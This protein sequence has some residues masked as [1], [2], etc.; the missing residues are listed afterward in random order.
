[1][2]VSPA[3]ATKADCLA[4]GVYA[5]GTLTPAARAVDAASRGA[6]RAAL[7]SGDASGKRGA[8]LLLRSLAQVSAPRVLL[9]GLGAAAEF[10]DK[11]F[12]EAVRAAV[13]NAGNSVRDLAL[14]ALDWKVKGH[15]SAWQARMVAMV[16]RD[17]VFRSDE[18]KSRKDDDA[19]HDHRQG[20]PQRTDML[21]PYRTSTLSNV[22][23]ATRV[24]A[25]YC[26]ETGVTAINKG[27]RLTRA[28]CRNDDSDMRSMPGAIFGRRGEAWPRADRP[29]QQLRSFLAAGGGG[30]RRASAGA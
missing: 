28:G 1:M 9:V 2:K 27:S 19:R 14:A 23:I 15:D 17:A 26:S 18:L 30:R 4:V 20:A 12:A 21:T 13:R 11:A 5:D 16:A 29:L 10:T 7:K 25:V 8:T 6:V 22:I 24:H 3:A